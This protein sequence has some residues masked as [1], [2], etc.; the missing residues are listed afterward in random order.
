MTLSAHWGVHPI[1]ACVAALGGAWGV[2]IG[3]WWGVPSLP[4][5]PYLLRPL[6]RCLRPSPNGRGNLG[7]CSLGGS[8]DASS[9][10][11]S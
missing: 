2:T 10:G 4:G 6:P 3:P 5:W 8:V 1:C 7:P 9:A 11:A